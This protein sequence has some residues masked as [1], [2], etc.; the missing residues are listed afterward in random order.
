MLVAAGV[1]INWLVPRA[2]SQTQFADPAFQAAWE[3]QDGPVAAGSVVRGWVWGPVT[4]RTI[5]E[6][7]A[8]IPGNSHMVQYFDKGRMEINNPNGDKNDPFYVTNGLLAVELISGLEQ[9]GVTQF[10]TLSPA[11][12]NLA[13]DSDDPTA[14]TYQ[15]FNG[16]SNIPGAPNERLLP[17]RPDRQC[18]PRSTARGVPSPGP[19]RAL[20]TG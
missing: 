17:T 7:F 19:R 14:P 10:Q 13:A 4:G 5:N 1:G 11:T 15:S 20:T 12:I 18:V 6:P 8:G 9:T 2:S 16:V 3:R